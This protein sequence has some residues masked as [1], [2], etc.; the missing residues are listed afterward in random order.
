[1]PVLLFIA[2]LLFYNMVYAQRTANVTNGNNRLSPSSFYTV[3]GAPFVNYKFINLINSAPYF[4]NNGL[5]G[6]LVTPV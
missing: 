5:R 4:S 3:V 1:M 6:M 2:L